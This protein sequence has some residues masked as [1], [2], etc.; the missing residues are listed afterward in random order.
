VHDQL[1]ESFAAFLQ[2]RD[3]VAVDLDDLDSPRTL[4][5]GR[6]QRAQA[7]AYLHQPLPRPGIDRIDNPADDAAVVKKV[8]AESLP[9]AMTQGASWL[10][11][12]GSTGLRLDGSTWT[13]P[14]RRGLR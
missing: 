11:E 3:D 9:G 12:R 7:G 8:L 5:Q 6:G 4:Q 2:Q 14:D 1:T 10:A 13:M